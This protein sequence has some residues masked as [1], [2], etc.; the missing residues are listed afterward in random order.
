MWRQDVLAAYAERGAEIDHLDGVT[1]GFPDRRFNLRPSNP[2]PLLRPNVEAD[3]RPTL[4]RLTTEVLALV[5]GPCG[6]G[7]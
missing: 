5:G 4:E 3:D 2:E 7:G 6:E 1:V